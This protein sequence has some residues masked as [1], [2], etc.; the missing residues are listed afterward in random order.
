VEMM[1]TCF[2]KSD[3]IWLM[4][5][6]HGQRRQHRTPSRRPTT[7]HHWHS[8]VDAEEIRTGT[9]YGRLAQHPR[10]SRS[11]IRDNAFMRRCRV[12]VF[13]RP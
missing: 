6:W 13:R 8:E 12:A 4:R 2:G 5:P 9:A 3:R 11:E 1:E 7:L 10:R